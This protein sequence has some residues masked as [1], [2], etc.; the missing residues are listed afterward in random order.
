[1]L[2]GVLAPVLSQ[3][4]V[5]AAP[6]QSAIALGMGDICTVGGMQT[7]PMAVDMRGSAQGVGDQLAALGVA[8]PGQAGDPD[9]SKDHAGH[10]KHC[11]FCGTH[12]V[13]L[14]LPSTAPV[15]LV[16]QPPTR[17]PRLFLQSPRPLSIWTT[18]QSRAPPVSA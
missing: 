2:F 9:Q 8:F 15:F 7:M 11:A 12:P 18:A 10:V 4:G 14:A 16:L 1:M 17:H 5:A 3:A 6:P 13:P